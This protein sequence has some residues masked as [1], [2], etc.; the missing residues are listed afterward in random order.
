MQQ[1]KPAD[2][3]K[4][5]QR[6]TE[7]YYPQWVSRVDRIWDMLEKT[8]LN[9]ILSGSAESGYQQ[10][11]A[12]GMSGDIDPQFQEYMG[13]MSLYA[14]VKQN[15]NDR[16]WISEEDIA[17]VMNRAPE[18][19]KLPD[20]IQQ[21]LDNAIHEAFS[22]IAGER[23]N[24]DSGREVNESE[25]HNRIEKEKGYAKVWTK[26][27]NPEGEIVGKQRFSKLYEDRSQYEIFI[28]DNG[29]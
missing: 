17:T 23:V 10:G 7:K 5:A 29:E 16:S 8:N 4:I 12:L 20:A 3:K 11:N 13:G 2:L 27:S 26:D 18:S 14:Y 19:I 21:N 25:P 24:Q 22:Y 15:T 1:I 28:L 6:F 9:S